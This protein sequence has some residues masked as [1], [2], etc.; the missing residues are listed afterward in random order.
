MASLKA[1]AICP[2]PCLPTWKRVFRAALN[3]HILAT[4]DNDSPFEHSFSEKFQRKMRRVI[5]MGNDPMRYR[6]QRSLVRA[7]C[8]LI[9]SFLTLMMVSPSA[10]AAVI[11]WIKEHYSIYT[12]YTYAGETEEDLYEFELTYLPDEYELL[13]YTKKEVHSAAANGR[14]CGDQRPPCGLKTAG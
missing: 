11:S 4:L 2:A 12:K 13:T 8:I 3:A 10:R 1:C 5:R 14:W 6:I 9:L 7:A